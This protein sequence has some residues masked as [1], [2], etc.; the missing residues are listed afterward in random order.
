MSRATVLA[1]A[2]CESTVAFC[3][4]FNFVG[5]LEKH[6]LLQVACL[7]IHVGDAVLAV[8]CD[9]LGC[10]R[11]HQAQEGHLDGN[12]TSKD[13]IISTITKLEATVHALA[14][15]DVLLLLGILACVPVLLWDGLWARVDTGL[16]GFQ[17]TVYADSI[18]STSLVRIDPVVSA[19]PFW[20]THLQVSAGTG[21]VLPGSLG[22]ADVI[23]LL[24]Q[25]FQGGLDL[26]VAISDDTGVV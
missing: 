19:T 17:V 25:G 8:V 4:D 23:D 18:Q 22:A 21:W 13:A 20:V 7:L 26:G 2:V 3:S 16:T 12:V 11:G 24:G 10:L 15:P 1:D 14:E 6:S 5:A 9:V